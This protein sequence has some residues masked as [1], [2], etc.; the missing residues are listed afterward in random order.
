MGRK[1]THAVWQRPAGLRA[2]FCVALSTLLVS[3][4]GTACAAQALPTVA[5]IRT[6]AL[7][8][9]GIDAEEPE[10]STTDDHGSRAALDA[11][12]CRGVAVAVLGANAHVEATN[13][14]DDTAAIAALKSGA[15]DLIPTLS[16][17]FSHT[18]GTH[19]ALTRPVLLDGVGFLLYGASPAKSARGLANKKICFLAETGVEEIVR[20]WF[21]REHLSFVPF[22]FQEEGEMQAAF[23]TNNCG[24]LAGER[25]R[26][27]QTQATLAEHGRHSRLLSEAISRD[28][29]AAAV[30]DDDQ[31]WFAIV[32]WVM[33]ALLAAE[34]LGITQANVQNMATHAAQDTNPERRFLLGGSKQIGDALDLDDAW[35]V[36]VIEATGNYGEIYERDLGSGSAM[37]LPRG[38]N[39]LGRDG[40]AMVALPFH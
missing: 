20:T 31:Q 30:R 9:C 12:L 35:A 23:T 8:R 6:A 29:L 4:C 7:L 10:Y 26:L 32:N 33:E 24:A 19:L 39:K 1:A 22:P 27:A 36:R 34:E 15:V 5:H 14:P 13:F 3:A 11:D 16:D 17:D 28:P 37:K 21:G 18:V 25:T 38:I 2:A 40:G